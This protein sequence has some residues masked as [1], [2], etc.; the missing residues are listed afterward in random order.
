MTDKK[1]VREYLINKKYLDPTYFNQHF[2]TYDIE[3]LACTENARVISQKT[4]ANKN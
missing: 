3:S 2:L 4:R 1:E